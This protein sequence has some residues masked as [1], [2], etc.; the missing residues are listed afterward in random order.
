[1]NF[2]STLTYL[3]SSLQEANETFDDIESIVLAIDKEPILY[4]RDQNPTLGELYLYLQ[5]E[6]IKIE[7]KETEVVYH[8]AFYAYTKN[9]VHFVIFDS[10]LSEYGVYSVPRYPSVNELPDF[11]G[12]GARIK[13][14]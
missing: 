7:R 4:R 1:M 10:D 6:T 3:Q 5:K 13:F 12:T 2:K 11:I 8:N 14:T 9:R